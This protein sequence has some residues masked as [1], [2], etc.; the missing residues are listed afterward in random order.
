MLTKVRALF[1]LRILQIK[2]ILD[3]V[4][5][6]LLAV[7]AVS[8][9]GIFAIALS[10]ILSINKWGLIPTCFLLLVFVDFYRKDKDFL[11]TIFYGTKKMMLFLSIEYTVILFPFIVFHLIRQHY[12]L[13]LSVVAIALTVATLSTFIIKPAKI[14]IKKEI[15]W[16]PIKYFELKFA[17]ESAPFS[18]LIIWLAGLF[19][20]LHIG[21]FL[22]WIFLILNVI[23]QIFS[24]FESR[25]MLHWIPKFVAHKFMSYS[26]IFFIIISIPTLIAVIYHSEKIG[27]II[28]ALVCVFVSILLA[29][30]IKYESCTPV[31]FSTH[32]SSISSFLI[33]LMI[34]PGGVIITLSYALQK[35]FKAE[36]NIKSLYA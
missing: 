26:L 35:Y 20:F 25:E 30:V 3:A 6:L 36:K 1:H 16:I 8:F 32:V 19:S 24:A 13:S 23:P 2:R 31:M 9:V 17:A 18:Y 34:L 27:I 12:I 28:Y 29:L 5:Y 22:F 10:N 14:S 21:F 33:L 4:G 7:F 15:S 11:K